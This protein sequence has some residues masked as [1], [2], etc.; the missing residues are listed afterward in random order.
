MDEPFSAL[1]ESFRIPLRRAFRQLQQRLDQ[2]C[3]IV[4]HDREEAFELADQVAVMFEGRIAQ[5]A[6]PA[7]LWQQPA[8][9]RVADFLGAFNA[10]DPRRLPAPWQ[11][12]DGHWLAPISALALDPDPSAAFDGLR[13]NARVEAVYAGTERL[14]VQLQCEG[15]LTLHAAHGQALPEPGQSAALRVAAGALRWVGD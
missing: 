1:D 12:D 15:P 10:F 7:E 11:R 8:S 13:L 4:T 5:C 14:T 2:S 9:R 6:S 3:L